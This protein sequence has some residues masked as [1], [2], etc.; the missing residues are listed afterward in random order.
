MGYPSVERR[1]VLAAAALGRASGVPGPDPA[2]GDPLRA[3][4]GEVLDVSPHLITIETPRA[5]RSGW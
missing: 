4:V 3:V 5:P 1:R 2:D